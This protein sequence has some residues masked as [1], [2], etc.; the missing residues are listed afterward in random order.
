MDFGEVLTNA[1]KIIW[2]FKV[3]WIFGI[4]SSCGQGGGGGGGGGG[5][6]SGVQYSPSEGELPPFMRDFVFGMERFFNNIE[7]WQI[8]L[9]IIGMIVFILVLTFIFAAL[10]TVGRIGLVQGTIEAE[11]GA[12]TLTFMG[13]FEQGKPLFWRIFGFNLLVGLA[14]FLLVLIFMVPFI[15]IGVVT[16]GIGMLCLI[17]LICILVPVGWLAGV[18]IEQANIAIIVEDLPMLAG[19]QR[20]WEVF[21]A[22]LG[23]MIVMALI[24]V[25]GGGVIGFAMALPI[26][27]AIVPLIIGGVTAAAGEAPMFAG[28]G[29]MVSLV[30]CVSYLPVL[31]VLSGILQAYIKSAWTLTYVRL[32]AATDSQP[33]VFDS[34]EVEYL[35]EED[36]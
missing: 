13:L 33:D 5:G 23:N 4:L 32:A 15:L 35:P 31:I 29:A 3:L 10:N 28:G 6:N 24:L 12:E 25:L 17:P 8:A 9:F 22:N 7:G 20:G 36:L 18:V 2:K 30:C 11:A 27:F 21:R 16:M 19:L 14:I 26:M 1:W 34:D